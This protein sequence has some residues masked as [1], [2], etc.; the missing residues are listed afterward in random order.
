MRTRALSVILALALVVAACGGDDNAG[1]STGQQAGQTAT[2]K[3]ATIPTAAAAPLFVGIDRGFFKQEHLQVKTKFAEGGA[4]IIPAVQSGDVDFGFGNTVSLFIAAERGLRLPIVAAGQVAPAEESKDETAVMVPAKSRIRTIQDL[5]GAT[6]GVNTLQNI[7]QLSISSA[8][9]KAGV[10]SKTVK[11]TEVPFPEALPTIKSGDVDA[12]FFGEPFTT[13]GEQAKAR[14]IFRPFS[15]GVPGGQIGAY[16]ASE[17]YVNDQRDVVERFARAIERANRYVID[18]PDA[19][20]TAV[21][22][23][24]EVPTKVA[25]TM[26]LPV[27]VPTID[28]AALQKLA[29]LSQ[30]YGLIKQHLNTGEML[31]G[32]QG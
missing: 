1:Q 26:R 31:V 8:L 23:F 18:H 25:Q 9:D 12:A 4:A 10:D 16:F 15:A 3:V 13:L 28:R 27:F 30:K 14:I 17:R 22:K 32:G 20:R 19:V 6:I 5:K 7:S 29:D 24:T 11:Y 21:P 2:V